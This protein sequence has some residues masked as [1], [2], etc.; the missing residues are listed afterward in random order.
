MQPQQLARVRPIGRISSGA[1]LIVGRT[2]PVIDCCTVTCFTGAL[3]SK[4]RDGGMARNLL[5]SD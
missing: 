3:A 5:A 1:K 2:V 4:Y